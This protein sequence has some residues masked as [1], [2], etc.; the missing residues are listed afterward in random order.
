MTLY[1]FPLML[2]NLLGFVL[3]TLVTRSVLK[4]ARAIS[5]SVEYDRPIDGSTELDG[6][7]FP[8]SDLTERPKYSPSI[9][10]RLSKILSF[11]IVFALTF[12]VL[13]G[14][15]FIYRAAT[16]VQNAGIANELK[17][18]IQCIFSDFDGDSERA[19]RACG[20]HANNRNS[21][22]FVYTLIPVILIPG[23]S[24]FV[25]IQFL[26]S[27]IRFFSRRCYDDMKLFLL[28]PTEDQ[29]AQEAI[30]ANDPNVP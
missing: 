22:E 3:M 23:Q 19:Y 18:W 26:P 10:N 25:C 5:V 11:Q 12:S 13:W 17:L 2:S 7:I 15:A 1:Y 27:A 29:L 21:S 6:A 9:I 16:F 4:S 14:I 24:F 30:I 20:D 8:G 28:P